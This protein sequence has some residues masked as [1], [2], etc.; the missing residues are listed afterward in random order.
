MAI[1]QEYTSK[2]RFTAIFIEMITENYLS[3]KFYV[4]DEMIL[5]FEQSILDA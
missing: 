2:N 1:T 5:V 4:D 3:S